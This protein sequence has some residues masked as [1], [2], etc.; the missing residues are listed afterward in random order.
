MRHK[1]IN[2]QHVVYINL[3]I[4]DDVHVYLIFYFMTAA[5]NIIYM[6]FIAGH[7]HAVIALFL[8]VLH[9]LCNV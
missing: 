9:A 6:I 4:I 8:V 7:V 1:I 5:V 2:V 3:I